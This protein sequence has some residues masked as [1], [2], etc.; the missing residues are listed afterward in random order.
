[1][2]LP[3][4]DVWSIPILFP[5]PHKDIGTDETIILK[6]SGIEFAKFKVNEVFSYDSKK[7]IQQFFETDDDGREVKFKGKFFDDEGKLLME[8]DFNCCH[9]QIAR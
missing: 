6:F 8:G 2:R 9:H 1:M 7:M 3:S 5:K 4:G